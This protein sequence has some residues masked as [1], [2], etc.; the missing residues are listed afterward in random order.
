MIQRIVFGA[1][2]ILLLGG[3]LTLDALFHHG[4]WGGAVWRD[5]PAVPILVLLLLALGRGIW[6]LRRIIHGGGLRILSVSTVLCS[7]ALLLGFWL[8]GVGYG[9]EPAEVS[10]LITFLD[11][12]GLEVLLGLVLV[13]VFCEQMLRYRLDDALR[14]VGA[15]LLA[16][17]YLGLGLG[18]VLA[19]RIEHGP[20]A[21]LL[22]LCTV[23]A[24]DIGA[25]FVGSMIGRHKL[26]PWLSPGKSWEGLAGAIFGALLTS[27]LLGWLLP[28]ASGYS[29]LWRVGFGLCVGLFGQFGDFC[30]SLLKRSAGVKDS[31]QLVPEFGGVLDMLDSPLLAAPAALLLLGP[32]AG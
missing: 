20:G 24:A 13:A 14:Q 10:G 11:H 21:L 17:L 19:V 4:R 23:K 16:V 28:P 22:F 9:R 18:L 5:W 6:E 26:I 2:L 1:V 32:F 27:L 12:F 15:T 31:G 25:Y 7:M 30:E 3:V 8:R 29:L